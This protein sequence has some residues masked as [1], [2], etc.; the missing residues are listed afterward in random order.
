MPK[1]PSVAGLLGFLKADTLEWV[2]FPDRNR[3]KGFFLV[4]KYAIKVKYLLKA[5]FT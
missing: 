2:I 4:S 3:Q 5:L 1:F